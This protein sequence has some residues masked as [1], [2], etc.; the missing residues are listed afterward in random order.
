MT[1]DRPIAVSMGEPAGIGIEVALKAW[2]M[3]REAS[4]SPFL[5]IADVDAVARAA[6]TLGEKIPLQAIGSPSE[7]MEQFDDC[8]PLSPLQLTETEEP[9]QPSPANSGPVLEAIERGVAWCLDGAAAAIVTNPIQKATLYRSGFDYPGHTE[10]LGHLSKSAVTPV[11]MLMAPGLRVVPVTVHLALREVFERLTGELIEES[12]MTV[13]QALET[14]FAITAPRLAV[15][16]LN[17]H[18]GEEGAMGREEIEIIEPAIRALRGRGI[19]IRG[20]FPADTMFHAAARATYDAALCMYHDQ[21]NIPLKTLAFDEGV[22]VT[23]GLPIIRTSPDHG[24]ALDIAGRGRAS[25]ASLIAS[26]QTAA[27]IARNRAPT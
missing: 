20:P 23:L 21:A 19:D 10:L 5:L 27:T 15:A 25:P 16:G 17:P 26:L 4:L 12:A 22:N 18:A 24:T 6:A 9:G 11:M 14:D 8:L 1:L 2:M 3:R 7:A 13:A